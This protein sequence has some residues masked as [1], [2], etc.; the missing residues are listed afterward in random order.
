MS[1]TSQGNESDT[2]CRLIKA[3]LEEFAQCGYKGTSTRAITERAGVNE[4]TLFRHFGSKLGLLQAAVFEAF[5]QTRLPHDVNYYLQFPLREGLTRILSEHA[6]QSLKRSTFFT[7]GMAESFTHPDIAD[8]LKSFMWEL[9]I[10]FIEYL[11]KLAAQ[12][13]LRQADFHVLA[14][15]V[16]SSIYTTSLTRQRAPEEISKH[17]VDEKIIQSLVEMIISVY[18]LEVDE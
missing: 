1:D 3:A 11:K 17:L 4:V 10:T 18:G 6:E 9:R 8:T 14:H 12:N 16:L 7:L 5:E 2:R 13:K 15:I